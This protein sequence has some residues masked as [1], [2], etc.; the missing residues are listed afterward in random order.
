ME[1]T[2]HALE[3]SGRM[4]NWSNFGY[5]LTFGIGALG[6]AGIAGG[7]FRDVV[8]LWCL[9]LIAI[10]PLVIF[11][12][13]RHEYISARLVR[14]AHLIAVIWY[15]VATTFLVS[16][17]AFNPEREGTWICMLSFLLVGCIPC[18]VVLYRITRGEY[19]PKEE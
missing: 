13:F 4:L 18:I 7:L 3:A 12:F 11:L 9:I 10:A 15:L 1:L 5:K 8:P 14:V 6:M 2:S 19:G 16:V 17:S